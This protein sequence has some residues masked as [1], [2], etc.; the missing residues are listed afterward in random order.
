MACLWELLAPDRAQQRGSETASFVHPT[1]RS[2]LVAFRSGNT[3]CVLKDVCIHRG[4][5]PVG[6]IGQ[7]RQSGCNYHGWAYDSFRACRS[8]SV[9]TV[10]N[11]IKQE[12]QQRAD[13]LS[14]PPKPPALYGRANATCA[15][16]QDGPE[17][18]WDRPRPDYSVLTGE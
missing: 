14:R 15:A 11:D 6:R 9:V 13:R 12:G 4:S 1:A 18:A 17:D 5:S 3:I 8:H 10:C 7:G 16:F 2:A